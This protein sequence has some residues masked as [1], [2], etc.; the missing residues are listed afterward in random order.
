MVLLQLVVQLLESLQVFDSDPHLL[1][2]LSE[3]QVTLSELHKEILGTEGIVQLNFEIFD[4]DFCVG[5]FNES[6]FVLRYAAVLT[7]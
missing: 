7:T 1:D 3:H 6:R 2:L 5:K 4:L